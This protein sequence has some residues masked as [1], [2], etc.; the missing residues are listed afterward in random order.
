MYHLKASE[1][2]FNAWKNN[3]ADELKVCS[4]FV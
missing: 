3:M 1:Y 4:A 2:L